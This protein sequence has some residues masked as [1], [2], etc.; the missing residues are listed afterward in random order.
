[1]QPIFYKKQP[2]VGSSLPVELDKSVSEKDE[3]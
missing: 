2:K 3:I 1:M